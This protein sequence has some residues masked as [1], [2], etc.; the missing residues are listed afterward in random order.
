MIYILGEMEKNDRIK[1][2]MKRERKAYREK[3][4]R[5]KER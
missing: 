2:V 5:K 4:D 1:A 3:R